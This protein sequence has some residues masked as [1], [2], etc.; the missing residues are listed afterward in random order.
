[1]VAGTRFG[2]DIR[3]MASPISRRMKS[4]TNP[5]TIYRFELASRC[6]RERW[7]SKLATETKEH[8]TS[9]PN[10][11]SALGKNIDG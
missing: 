8:S 7:T 9:S 3:T 2:V 1:L 10:A 6:R 4:D 11:T 5:S